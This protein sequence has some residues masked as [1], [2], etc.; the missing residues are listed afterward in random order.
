MQKE[1]FNQNKH[2]IATII[3]ESF[4]VP[5]LR[6]LEK[7]FQVMKLS[8]NIVTLQN[9]QKEIFEFNSSTNGLVGKR[10]VDYMSS[11]IQAKIDELKF[12]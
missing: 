11:A 4:Y 3:G 8:E 1:V 12:P 6:G 5:T 10:Y 2:F 7:R 9:F